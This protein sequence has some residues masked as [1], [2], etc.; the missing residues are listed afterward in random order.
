MSHSGP[1]Q[2]PLPGEW[3]ARP[4]VR[5]KTVGLG[6]LHD[7]DGPQLFSWINDPETVRMNAAYAP[8]HE[9]NHRAWM[10]HIGDEQGRIVFGIRRL[11]DDRLIGVVQLID[12]H[13]VHHSAE[14]TIRIGEEDQR[15]RGA[16]TEAVQLACEFAFHDHNLQRVWLRVFTDNSRAIRSY[17]KAG[18]V[19]EGAMR[20]AAFIDGQWRDL[21][22]MARLRATP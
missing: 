17:V 18:F 7:S 12:I 11:I 6:P 8:V 21:A 22:I 4:M 16:G 10:A 2:N 5:G 3:R 15:G 19:H 14:L 1:S 20:R 13:P 9:P